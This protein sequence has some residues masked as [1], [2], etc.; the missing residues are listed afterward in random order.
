MMPIQLS[1]GLNTIVDD[2]DFERLNQHKWCALK[3]SNTY[4]AVRTSHKIGCK[5]EIIY[6]HSVIIGTPKGSVTDHINGNGLDNRRVNLRVVT[7]RENKQNL[8]IKK[9][10]K[11]PGVCWNKDSKKWQANIRIC[12]KKK[13]LGLFEDE[14]AA[15]R[16][17][18]VALAAL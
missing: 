14:T 10:S 1:Q 4:Y 8:H 2:E 15:A 18:D 11:Y 13:H 17:Y 3:S 9:S 5:N 16:A 7:I 6:M 12:G